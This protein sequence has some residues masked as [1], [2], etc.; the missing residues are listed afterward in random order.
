MHK[1]LTLLLLLGLA[2][3]STAAEL[4]GV[5][6]EDTARIDDATLT[7]NGLGLRKKA[8]FKVYVGGLYLTQKQSDPAT[9]LEADE[10]RRMVLEFVRNVSASSISDAWNDCLTANRP[11]A[12]EP[13]L[14]S[15]E[16]LSGWMED[17]SKGD[18]LI[19]TYRP[20]QSTRVSVKG[21]TRGEVDGKEFADALFECWIGD[22][23][24]SE[25]FKKGLL[26]N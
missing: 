25:D 8:I 10:P 18:R 7:L 17:V 22:H 16:M 12:A 1:L 19:F 15:F 24:P 23:P 13:L 11:Q 14:D 9:I 4:A 20:G 6:M 3:S 21:K 5:D 26:G 2:Q